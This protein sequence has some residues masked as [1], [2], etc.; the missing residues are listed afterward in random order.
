MNHTCLL[1]EICFVKCVRGGTCV[2]ECGNPFVFYTQSGLSLSVNPIVCLCAEPANFWE[3]LGEWAEAVLLLNLNQ[4]SQ[5][6]FK[7]T[8][9]LSDLSR[10]AGRLCFGSS[11]T[12][13]KNN[14]TFWLLCLLAFLP[15]VKVAASGLLALFSIK[16]KKK[17]IYCNHH[18]QRS[19]HKTTN[20]AFQRYF[21]TDWTQDTHL[22]LFLVDRFCNC[23]LLFS[24]LS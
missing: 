9:Q 4:G 1:V 3:F 11:M 10:K 5:Q 2:R 14:I 22:Q 13:L 12:F 19:A 21:G 7:D 16:K 17:I 20:C 18:G 15:K 23:S 8:F 6:T 24:V